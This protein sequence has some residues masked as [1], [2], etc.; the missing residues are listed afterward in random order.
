MLDKFPVRQ[1]KIATMLGP[2]LL[3]GKRAQIQSVT[4]FDIVREQF[5]ADEKPGDT[6]DGRCTKRDNGANAI[7]SNAT[8]SLDADFHARVI[9]RRDLRHGSTER[10]DGVDDLVDRPLLQSVRQPV[11]DL[12]LQ[13]GPSSSAGA[14]LWLCG[15]LVAIAL[16][17][18]NAAHCIQ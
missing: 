5:V 8:V 1:L 7:G 15:V 4:L 12:V 16:C 13:R 2:E 3:V 17:P 9:E 10:V 6:A 11:F 18:R 14:A